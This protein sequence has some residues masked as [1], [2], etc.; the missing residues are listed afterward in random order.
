MVGHSDARV[1]DGLTRSRGGEGGGWRDSGSHEPV[2][3]E[4][5]TF[6][7]CFLIGVKLVVTGKALPRLS[8]HATWGIPS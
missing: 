8:C 7:L 1:Y 4:A 5:K 6:F 2:E 3:R